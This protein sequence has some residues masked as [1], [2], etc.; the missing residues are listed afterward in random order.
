MAY[1][2]GQI[3]EKTLAL[4]DFMDALS[5]HAGT[6][7]DDPAEAKELL[8]KIN[9]ELAGV[10]DPFLAAA[11]GLLEK[12]SEGEPLS[13]KEAALLRDLTRL[14]ENPVDPDGVEVVGGKRF[15]LTGDFACA[16]GKDTAKELIKAAGG[17][18]TGGVSGRTDYV[19]V[20][21]KGSDAWAYGKF[22][23]KVKA[24]LNFRL[25]GKSNIRI[26]SEDAL[27]VALESSDESSKLLQERKDR[28]ERS[29]ASART[30][31]KDFSGL[32]E[33]QQRVMDLVERGVNVYL[34]GLG[35]TGKSY[36]L[37]KV[38]DR[39][40]ESG[41]GV[42][43]CAPTGIAALN[44]GGSTI[45]R[46][47]TIPPNHTLKNRPYVVLNDDSPILNCD[48]MIIDEIS[49]C[50]MDLFD[51]LSAVLRRAAKLRAEEGK[52]PCQLMVVGDFSQLPP[53]V[54]NE[55]RDL[56]EEKYGRKV[57]GAYPFLGDTWDDWN[58]EKVELTEAIRQRDASF[59]A[60]LNAVRVGDTR[61]LRWI[62]AHAAKEPQ[63]HSVIL[64]GTND[65]AREENV[66]RL[67]DLPSKETVYHG[68]ASGAVDTKD[69]AA[70]RA[71][72]LKPSA[73]VMA[74]VNDPGERFMNGSLG[75]V[76]S[77]DTNSVV[78]DFDHGE[79]VKMDAYRWSI[80]KPI[81]VDDKVKDDVIGTFE[82]IPLKLA[83]AMTIHKSQGQTFDAAVIHPN[84]WE[85][86]QLY[87]ALSR[88]TRV[89][90]MYIAEPISDNFLHTSP[91]VVAFLEKG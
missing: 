90:G 88:L 79:R 46:A 74:L 62:E 25:Q 43:V 49:M 67:N 53:V 9:D 6:V 32:T 36:V 81:K 60:A 76:V 26:V 30:V 82:Q 18:V 44:V 85:D 91:D 15:V 41:K 12:S 72:K 50:R 39:A 84:C 8:A 87:T 29:W 13:P 24:A 69:M 59:V 71:L 51:Y 48:L 20:G 21:S 83:W 54:P 3:S 22:G 65:E 66:R 73:R 40:K 61:G 57:G 68:V 47:L 1:S 86:G 64:C 52:P 80:T 23:T 4:K 2:F 58:F 27:M 75:T 45:H 34:T 78:V 19:V 33:G 35:G 31:S 16:G 56:L 7:A 55:D 70:D 5:A 42:I 10:E 28:Y 14:M 17:R 38:I 77:C 37:E 89:E 11:R 63:E